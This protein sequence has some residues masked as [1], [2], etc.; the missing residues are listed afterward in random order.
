MRERERKMDRGRERG[1]GGAGRAPIRNNIY[2][3][4]FSV[5]RL[6]SQE[7]RREEEDQKQRRQ[8]N[9]VTY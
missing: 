4:V 9:K 7:R 5:Q 1:T 8:D 3:N 2:S 6:R